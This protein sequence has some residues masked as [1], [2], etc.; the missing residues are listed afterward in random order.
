MAAKS[1]TQPIRGP[2]GM[3][4]WFNILSVELHARIFRHYNEF[5]TWPKNISIRY[6]TPNHT[7]R[8]KSIGTLHKDEMKTH[9]KD[10]A[11]VMWRWFIHILYR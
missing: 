1:F 7:Y 3:R 2:E 8:S 9:G 6:A 10:I 11:V 5:G 4:G